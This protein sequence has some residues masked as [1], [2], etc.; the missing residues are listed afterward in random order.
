[1]LGDEPIP[2]WDYTWITTVRNG[3]Q[4][5]EL[6]HD[7]DRSTNIHTYCMQQFLHTHLTLVKNFVTKAQ[8]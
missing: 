5:C 4:L 1:M 8:K 6:R 7:Q 2:V 3:H